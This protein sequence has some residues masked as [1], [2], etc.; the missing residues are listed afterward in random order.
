MPALAGGQ[1]RG[2]NSGVGGGGVRWGA[3][4]EQIVD[5]AGGLVDNTVDVKVSGSPALR[6]NVRGTAK[7]MAGDD[8]LQL[9]VVFTES[10]FGPATGSILP[11]LTIPLPRPK[12]SLRT[13]FVDDELRLSRGGRGGLFVLRRL[14]A[15]ALG[16]S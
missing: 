7:P 6:I 8:E 10:S 5:V 3:S 14:Q 15:P 2:S 11:T 12:G 1:E 9:E 4:N 16:D 13:T